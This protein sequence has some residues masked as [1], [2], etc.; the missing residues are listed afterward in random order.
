[1]GFSL[2]LNFFIE[3]GNSY[4]P[5]CNWCEKKGLFL[6]LNESGT[7]FICSSS[8]EM[9]IK[10]H[11]QVITHCMREVEE[12]QNIE[13]RLSG[14]EQIVEHAKELKVYERKGVA[15][16]NP[17]PSHL[18]TLYT[19]RQKVIVEENIESE[20]KKIVNHSAKEA[21]SVKIEKA[22]KVLT[23]IIEFKERFPHLQ[24]IE[25]FENRI[26]HYL[27]ET[28]LKMYMENASEAESKGLKREALE[29]YKEALQYLQDKKI[30][31]SDL[32]KRV[33]EIAVKILEHI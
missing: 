25:K 30:E 6:R 5:K 20:V 19:D 33:R 23:N 13:T 15:T 2:F 31:V 7:C 12:S 17:L 16:L 32:A 1:M 27:Y 24:E 21:A 22:H 3:S 18:I 9:D 4:M 29:Q 8:I 11:A 10:Q 26:N 14:C 28:Q